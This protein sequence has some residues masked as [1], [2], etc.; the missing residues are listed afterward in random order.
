[1]KKT[2]LV[3]V[4]GVLLNWEDGFQVWMEHQGHKRIKGHQFIYNAAEQFGLSK[5][6]GKKAVKMFNQSAAI[7]FLPPLRD[8]QE[9]VK[10]LNRN[11]GYRFVVCT[12]LSKDKSAQE[13]RTRNLE[14]YFGKVFDEFVYLDTGADKDEALYKLAKK[15]RGCLW[16]E[17][18]V[19]NAKVGDDV[20]FESIVMEHGYNMNTEH[21]YFV[22]KN[23]E[24]IYLHIIKRK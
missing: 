21:P 1:M 3:D 10:L 23:W 7:G 18:K 16:V 12:S 6:E 4:D 24:D 9:I 8:A 15:Y 17:D 5:P 14:K 11:W 13:L 2:I 19:E 22:A 20:G